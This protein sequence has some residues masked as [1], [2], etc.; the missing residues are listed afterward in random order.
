MQSVRFLLLLFR[1]LKVFDYT[2]EMDDPFYQ[3]IWIMFC[4]TDISTSISIM[5]LHHSIGMRSVKRTARQKACDPLTD[6]NQ[7]ILP[8][9]E[10]EAKPNKISRPQMIKTVSTEI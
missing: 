2:K 3:I 10:E 8:A 5:V 6:C 1:E 7:L 9:A 4:V